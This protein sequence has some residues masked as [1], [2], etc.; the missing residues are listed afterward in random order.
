MRNTDSHSPVTSHTHLTTCPPCTL[1]S[2]QAVGY[3]NGREV[4][5]DNWMAGLLQNEEQAKAPGNS[6]YNT[7]RPSLSLSLSVCLSLSLSLSLRA[8][9]I[10]ILLGAGGG[11]A[12]GRSQRAADQVGQR[13]DECLH[14]GVA[15][16]H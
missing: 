13:L 2:A 1:S 8:L 16:L 3:F 7:S 14:V 12:A 6:L 5:R 9:Q 4:L 10:E 11:S 15:G